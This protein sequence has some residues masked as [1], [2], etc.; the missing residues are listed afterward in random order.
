MSNKAKRFAMNFFSYSRLDD[1]SY[2]LFDILCLTEH[3][4]CDIII[5]VRQVFGL[6]NL[7][8][9]K[10]TG[11]DKIKV[12]VLNNLVPELSPILA[13]L[14]IRCLKKRCFNKPMND[15]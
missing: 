10:A 3:K 15:V 14:S 6:K 13:K 1:N 7:D 11:Q 5:S 2:S 4:L 8:S 12:V 9:T